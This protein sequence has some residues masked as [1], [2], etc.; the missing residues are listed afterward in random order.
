MVGAMMCATLV[1]CGSSSSSSDTSSSSSSGDKTSITLIM[2]LRDQFLSELE[3]SAKEQAADLGIELTTQDANNDTS[4]LIQ[5][6]ESARNAGDKAIIINMVDPATA[7][8]CIE[9]AGDMKVVFVNRY[10][11]DPSVLG[12]NAVYVGSNE[13]TSGAF[14]AEFLC[15]YFQKQGKTE[16]SYLMLQGTLGQTS[17]ENRTATVLQG[18][19]DGGITATAA[20]APLAADYDRATAMD[21][22]APLVDTVEYDCIISNND[23]MALGAIEALKSKDLDP[24]AIPIVGIDA[25]TA[26]REAIKSGELMMSVYQ[27]PHGQGQGALMAAVN[28]INGDP[29][30]N[31]TEFDLDETGHIVWVPFEPVTIDNVDNYN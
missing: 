4:K 19:A 12:D 25:S 16:I 10:P 2:A 20:A 31:G 9:A 30:N 11:T 6:I 14:Q 28:L 8:Q 3:A 21:M 24:T 18:L 7:A 27:N 29:I 13:L 1:G 17:T 15:D 5:Y 22:I 23:E 26:G